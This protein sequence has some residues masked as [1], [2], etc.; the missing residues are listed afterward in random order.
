[1]P[2]RSNIRGQLS[3]KTL[4]RTRE[5]ASCKTCLSVSQILAQCIFRPRISS[6]A[7]RSYPKLR[8]TGVPGVKGFTSQRRLERLLL[9]RAP[10]VDGPGSA[11]Q[12]HHAKR[13]KEKRLFR[14]AAK[15]LFC[16]VGRSRTMQRKILD[17]DQTQNTKRK[18]QNTK[19][20]CNFSGPPQTKAYM[21]CAN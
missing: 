9:Q 7:Y 11:T 3:H 12:L 16:I 4:I 15:S 13:K 14:S 17:E 1:M 5:I 19:R 8:L 21:F 18:T 2:G 6:K 20:K 10:Y